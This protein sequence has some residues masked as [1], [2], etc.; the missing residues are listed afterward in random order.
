[1]NIF[2]NPSIFSKSKLS[3]MTALIICN[4]I[5][6]THTE[7]LSAT[8]LWFKFKNFFF[9]QFTEILKQITPLSS[10]LFN[11]FR[12]FF[13]LFFELR[14]SFFKPSFSDFFSSCCR[15][16]WQRTFRSLLLLPS[17]LQQTTEGLLSASA[18]RNSS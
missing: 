11:L 12:S 7:S 14:P 6:A 9:L 5:S 15:L 1:M 4:K 18:S 2:K 10:W 8:Q 13:S 16:C 17:S 3:T